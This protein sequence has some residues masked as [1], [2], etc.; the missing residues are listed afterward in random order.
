MFETKNYFW[1]NTKFIIFS[2]QI[3]SN[4]LLLVVKKSDVNINPKLKLVTIYCIRF[5]VK[6]L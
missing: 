4:K 6:L 1:R 2:Q 3:L 5:I